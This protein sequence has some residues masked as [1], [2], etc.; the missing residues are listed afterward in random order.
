MHPCVRGGLARHN[1]LQFKSR[2]CTSVSSL[3]CT[4]TDAG[5]GCERETTYVCLNNGALGHI[6]EKFRTNVE[7]IIR[8]N[9]G[10][11]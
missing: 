10:G 5:M 9:L 8:T 3:E 6:L 11:Y 4:C 2:N 7:L 1:A